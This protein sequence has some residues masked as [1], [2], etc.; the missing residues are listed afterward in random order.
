MT[1][2]CSTCRIR[3]LREHDKPVAADMKSGSEILF[4][5]DYPLEEDLE[6]GLVLSGLHRRAT[7]THRLIKETK[8]KQNNISHATV[9]RCITKSKAVLKRDDYEYCGQMILEELR[10][11]SIKAVLCFGSLAGKLISGR[12]IESIE[13]TRGQI[14]ESVI[15]GIFCVI[16]YSMG[17]LTD[18][19]GCGGCGMG[20]QPYLAR[21]DV[22]LMRKEYLR[23]NNERK[24]ETSE[25]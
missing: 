19:R 9:I 25:S 11:S 4:V 3:L 20:A 15:P 23:R 13:M 6:F 12:N 16:T 2:I 18:P 1:D 7:F 24:K 17:I 14:F 8:L 10:D 5:T 22:Q 21:K